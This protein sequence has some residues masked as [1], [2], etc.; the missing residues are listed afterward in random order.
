MPIASERAAE[1]R[2][3][4]WQVVTASRALKGRLCVA[5]TQ[6]L[7]NST[8]VSTM[9]SKLGSSSNNASNSSSDGGG[10]GDG[11]GGE[12]SGGKAAAA[13]VSAGILYRPLIC[14]SP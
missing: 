5:L 8:G 3:T 11:G 10:G 6:A 14:Y 12:K 4:V 2:V 13:A 7:Q 1:H 9:S